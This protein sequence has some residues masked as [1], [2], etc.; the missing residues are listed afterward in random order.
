MKKVFLLL[1]GGV[2]GH[3]SHLYDNRDLSFNEMKS[4]LRKASAGKL[5][6]TEKTDGYNIYLGARGG[7]SLYA[8]NK[9]DMVAGGRNISDLKMR[10]FAGGDEVKDVYLNSFRSF[11]K[12]IDS[13]S[14]EEQASIFGKN[15]E[16]FYN[17]EI[18]GPGASNVVNYDA[19]VLSIH[20]GGHKA[21]DPVRQ[22]VQ[23]VDVE[24]N[25]QIL[26]SM[27]DR[28]EQHG[29][30]TDFSVRRTAAVQLKALGD[31]RAFDETIK[32]LRE[33]GFS[34]NMTIGDFLEN[35]LREI[36][37]TE[38]SYFKPGVQE[39]VVDKILGRENAKNL[40]VIYQGMGDQ[41]KDAIR[42]I[43]KSGPK[44]LS[45]IIFPIEDAIHDFSVEMLK[46]MESAYI[47]DNQAELQ[48][49]RAEVRGAIDQ[50]S[51]YAG[52]GAEEA[53]EVLKKQ[54][55]KL[56]NHDNINT[57]VEGFVFQIGDQMY[58]FTGNFAPINQLLGLFR[59][60]RGAAP[61]IMSQGSQQLSEGLQAVDA[62][63]PADLYELLHSY[64]SVGVFAGGF[65]PPHRGHLEAAEKMAK[66]VDMPIVIMGHAAKTKPRMINDEPVTFETAAKLWEIYANDAGI[67][68]YI[69]EAPRG[70]NPMHI[71]YDILQNAKPGQT[72]HM[73]AGAKDAGRYRGQAEQYR[74]SGVNLN[75]EPMPNTMDPDTNAPMQATHFRQ[76]VEQ[77][78]DI[79]KFLPEKSVQNK[80]VIAKLL[81]GRVEPKTDPYESLFDMIEEQLGG[82][83]RKPG[84]GGGTPPE[85][86][87]EIAD[88][89]AQRLSAQPDEIMG[90]FEEIVMGNADATMGQAGEAV[91]GI[92]NP[93]A[94]MDP[95]SAYGQEL[96]DWA[97]QQKQA[98][99]NQQFQTGQAEVV[100]ET[101]SV[102]AGA[103]QGHVDSAKRDEEDE[104]KE[105]TIFRED[106]IE[107]ILNYFLQTNT[108]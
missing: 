64:D 63:S 62:D 53:H 69:L 15:G 89:V 72:I 16:I 30:Q 26:D 23:T 48:R 52:P 24:Q 5:V 11:Q 36:L 74:P 65:K 60:G 84:G 43:I 45:K 77:G 101:S 10:E 4:I 105:P 12:L 59:Y 70:G 97:L 102:G 85:R 88:M 80:E 42:E 27:L 90:A 31:D 54:L 50:I 103:V 67:N 20:H 47:L 17:T 86:F 76:A 61:A 39:D 57:T 104:D 34:G 19:N 68:L 41:E 107:E 40:R 37:S 8:R 106:M 9:G 73:V 108:N 3:L 46:G 99:K 6:G 56:K 94:I 44:F 14:P 38:M 93:A 29:Q 82:D 18:Q 21:Y 81:A 66:S 58:K 51:T 71:A 32:R 55:S 78:N 49:L 33:A 100:A 1:E 7:L 2:A 83:P 75:V 91:T 13:T 98:E 96:E 92:L 25:S 87:P 35:G 95:L 79:T 22:A 28:F